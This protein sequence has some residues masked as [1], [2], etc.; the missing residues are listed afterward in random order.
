MERGTSDIDGPPGVL[1][2]VEAGEVLWKRF[3]LESLEDGEET[4]RNKKRERLETNEG[5]GR[6]AALHGDNA[7]ISRS[8]AAQSQHIPGPYGANAG[9]PHLPQA[10]AES[11][12]LIDATA[13]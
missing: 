7:T 9:G 2:G 8:S 12:T 4:A 5:I 11:Q 10:I 1:W 3:I 13:I 6:G